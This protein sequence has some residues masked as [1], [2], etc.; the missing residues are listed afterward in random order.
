[1]PDIARLRDRAQYFREQAKWLR[2]TGAKSSLNDARLRERFNEL[3]QECDI[4]AEKIERSINSE[5]QKS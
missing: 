3:A 1:V 2:E 4:I 5:T